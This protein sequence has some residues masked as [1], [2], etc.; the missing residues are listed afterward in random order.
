MEELNERCPFQAEC[1][2]RCAFEGREIECPFYASQA[3]GENVIPDQE[4]RHVELLGQDASRRVESEKAPHNSGIVEIPLNLIYPHPD[5]PRKDVG[6]VAEL[7]ESIRANGVL[8][9]L[10]VV[11]VDQVDA[12]LREHLDKIA[13]ARSEG[14]LQGKAYVAIIGHRRLA[15][16]KLAGLET[17]PCTVVSMSPEQQVATMLTENIQREALTPY[18]EAMGFQ[19]LQIGFGK[20]VAEISEMSG[21]SQGTVRN[22]LKLAKLDREKFKASEGRGATL[23]DYLRLNEIKDDDA[24]NNVLDKIG[25]PDFDN[26]LA[27]ELE[28]QK[29][30]E[31]ISRFEAAAD[32]FAKKIETADYSTME[33]WHTYKTWNADT[34]PEAPGDQDKINY[35]YTITNYGVAIYRDKQDTG[36][37]EE[38]PEER[39][40][41]EAKEAA[42]AQKNQLAEIR[43]RHF[44]LRR[45]FVA[46]F[47]CDKTTEK[48][49]MSFAAETMLCGRTIPNMDVLADVLGIDY[50]ADNEDRDDNPM[51]SV[52]AMMEHLAYIGRPR[53]EA[54]I[55]LCM[56]YACVDSDK[57]GY[58][59]WKWNQETAL[60]EYPHTENPNLDRLYT[61]LTALGYQ[62][63]EEEREMQ[64][65]A[66]P[67]F[68]MAET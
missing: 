14:D 43:A 18:E 5:N 62:M 10:T 27:K 61:L 44:K 65:G 11:P 17:V 21:F 7:A 40:K 37:P 32:G 67:L 3:K 50:D 42:D 33:L 47:L 48:S 26:A 4:A 54:G 45:N 55:L 13:H 36:E 8:Q 9:N 58:F 64:S 68:Q 28:R 1:G 35:Y 41:R 52:A 57:K 15:A 29:T 46:D 66:H 2:F 51:V 34:L 23:G 30:Q 16:A 19:Q 25:T 53:S 22:R 49:V 63:S 6:D 31:I 24:R 20:S 12:V 59:D 56:A 39:Q 38:T 60:Y